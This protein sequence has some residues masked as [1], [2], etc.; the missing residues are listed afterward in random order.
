MKV[1]VVTMLIAIVIVI[2]IATKVILTRNRLKMVVKHLA[3]VAEMTMIK[4]LP[5]A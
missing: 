2:L 3:M 5:M 4:K 1:I